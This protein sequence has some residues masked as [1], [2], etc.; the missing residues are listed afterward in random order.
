MRRLS[1]FE[2]GEWAA[3]HHADLY[4]PV[5]GEGLAAAPSQ[6]PVALLSSLLDALTPPITLRIEVLDPMGLDPTTPVTWT[7]PA[8]TLRSW[9]AANATWLEGDARLAVSL[10]DSGGQTARFD[11]HDLIWLEGDA[12]RFE[13]FILGAGLLPGAI[14]LPFPHAHQYRPEWTPAFQAML[15]RLRS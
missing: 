6:S 12:A 1:V 13:P 11:E 5:D 7:A 2:S 15:K 4:G 8:E 9:L 10:S 14:E 3:Y